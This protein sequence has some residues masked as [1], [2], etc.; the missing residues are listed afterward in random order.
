M[1]QYYFDYKISLWVVAHDGKIVFQT[2]DKVD[3]IRV[4]D[5]FINDI[6]KDKE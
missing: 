1:I 5:E 3:A 4:A 6:E 2:E